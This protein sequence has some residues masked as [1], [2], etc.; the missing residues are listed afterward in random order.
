M[1]GSAN[2][3]VVAHLESKLSMKRWC[4]MSNALPALFNLEQTELSSNDHYTPKWIFDLLELQF[5]IDVAAPPGGVPWIP[6][7]RFFTQADDGL[8]QEWHGLVWCNPPFSSILPW[9][10]RM[11]DHKNGIMLLPHFRGPWKK[12]V[13]NKADAIVEPD[14]PEIFFIKGGKEKSIFPPVFFAGWGDQAV[15]ALHKIGRVR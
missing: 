11:N 4:V 1:N 15:T 5:D 3:Q 7:K 2:A 13:W 8:S 12:E 6:A 10:S 9:V 14:V